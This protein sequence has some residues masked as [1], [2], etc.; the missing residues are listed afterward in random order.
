MLNRSHMQGC[1]HLNYIFSLIASCQCKLR[2]FPRPIVAVP[3]QVNHSFTYDIH[4][5]YVLL[6]L[7]LQETIVAFIC[8]LSVLSECLS[9][10]V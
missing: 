6:T 8:G 7:P 3:H 2:L 5:C 10:G 4:F 9:R 1:I